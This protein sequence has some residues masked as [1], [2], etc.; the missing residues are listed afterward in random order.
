MR[1]ATA[2][3]NVEHEKSLLWSW[4]FSTTDWMAIAT[5]WLLLALN[6]GFLS[7]ANKEFTQGR[8]FMFSLPWMQSFI[9]CALFILFPKSNCTRIPLVFWMCAAALGILLNTYCCS[10]IPN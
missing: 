2:N 6:A 10:P 4:S 9:L 7:I 5:P 8:A 1:E 3:E